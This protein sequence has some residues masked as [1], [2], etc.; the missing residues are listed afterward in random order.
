MHFKKWLKD[1]E[2][3]IL[4]PSCISTCTV[5]PSYLKMVSE[6]V[7]FSNFISG[8]KRWIGDA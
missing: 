2:N 7:L 6:V 1:L 5:T 3:K 4:K 8:M